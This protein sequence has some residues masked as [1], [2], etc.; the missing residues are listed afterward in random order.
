[1]TSETTIPGLRDVEVD[2]LF[3]ADA[4]QQKEGLLYVLGGAWTRTWPPSGSEYP[5][6]RLLPMAA[7]L[8]VPYHLTNQDHEIHIWVANVD[9]EPL[10]VQVKGTFRAGRPAD[11]NEGM[12]QVITIAATAPIALQS[13]GIYQVIAEVNGRVTKRIQ[14]EAL[15]KP[16]GR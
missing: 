6:Q 8:R 1:M 12:S 13:P 7:I 16:P 3:L 2:A 10:D 9:D 15:E 5:F 14:F 11:L 4:V